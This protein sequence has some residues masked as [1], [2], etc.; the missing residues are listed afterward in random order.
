MVT[1][2]Y[3]GSASVVG[4]V[5]CSVVRFCGAWCRPCGACEVSIYRYLLLLLLL[6]SSA[7]V[8]VLRACSCGLVTSLLAVATAWP[9]WV[10]SGG[11]I[12]DPQDGGGVFQKGERG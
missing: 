7:F 12:P 10:P 5:A 6:Y 11:P 1:L 2:I 8:A 3:I 4:R 9:P